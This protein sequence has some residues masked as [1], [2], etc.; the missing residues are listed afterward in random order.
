MMPSTVTGSRRLN[1]AAEWCADAA[2]AQNAS[3][4]APTAV[5]MLFNNF[6]MELPPVATRERLDA[7]RA[8]SFL[9]LA[10]LV[11]VAH[12]RRDR[13][14]RLEL[15]APHLEELVPELVLAAV[16]DDETVVRL[17]LVLDA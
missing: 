5:T 1:C 4:G 13:F 11:D 2:N 17:V 9:R 15:G 8:D 10:S 6:D 3:A 14:S 16:R 12:P 7:R